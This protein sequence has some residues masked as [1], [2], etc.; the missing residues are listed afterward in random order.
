M[1][2]EEVLYILKISRITLYNYTKEGKIKLSNDYYDKESIF[3][4]INIH[5]LMLF[6]LMYLL[7]N[8]KRI[9]FSF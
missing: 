4:L 8:K 2:A 6:I 9:Y 1:K 5:I 3:K 7:I